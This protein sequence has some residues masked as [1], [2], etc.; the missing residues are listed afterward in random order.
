VTF[1]SLSKSTRYDRPFFWS[2]MTA[3]VDRIH[4]RPFLQTSDAA[5]FH[6]PLP[7]VSPCAREKI[8]IRL[9]YSVCEARDFS[10]A[11]PQELLTLEARQG[12]IDCDGRWPYVAIESTKPASLKG[13]GEPARR[14]STSSAKVFSISHDFLGRAMAFSEDLGNIV[15]CV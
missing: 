11:A 10:V 5:L 2:P 14:P 1:L 9:A 4:I 12:G 13:T 6:V 15:P 3:I 8:P 7:G